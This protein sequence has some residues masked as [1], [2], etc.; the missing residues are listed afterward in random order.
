M[1]EE[2]VLRARKGFLRKKGTRGGAGHRPEG[3]GN[4]TSAGARWSK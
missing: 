4:C 2:S 1:W 3:E